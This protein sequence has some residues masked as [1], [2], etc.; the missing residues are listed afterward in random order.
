MHLNIFFCWNVVLEQ[1][2]ELETL[3][4]EINCNY[5]GSY[6]SVENGV[7]KCVCSSINCESDNVK[8]CGSD[9]QTYSSYCDL[10][11]F[12]CHKQTQISIA[13]TGQCS[14]GKEFL[15]ILIKF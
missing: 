8:I 1:Q 13:Y 11:K 12:S 15:M 5:P 7:P 2:Q 10:I 3:C 9:G 6:C 4:S 14:Q